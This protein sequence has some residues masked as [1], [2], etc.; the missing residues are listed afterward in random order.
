MTFNRPADE[1]FGKKSEFYVYRV[2][3]NAF[4]SELMEITGCHGWHF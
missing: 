1:N 3:D 4:R 2:S